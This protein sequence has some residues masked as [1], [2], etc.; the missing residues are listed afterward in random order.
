MSLKIVHNEYNLHKIEILNSSV[1][2]KSTLG[3]C[4]P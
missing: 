3:I 2:V 4:L 1:K